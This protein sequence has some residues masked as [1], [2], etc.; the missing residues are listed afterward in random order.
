VL[1]GGLQL[2]E[3][4]QAGRIR[5]ALPVEGVDVNHPG[6]G[7]LASGT[8]SAG[9]KFSATDR[10]ADVA[11]LDA[12]Y[13]A[14]N[15]L[16]VGSAITVAGT[17]FHLIGLVNQSQL[18]GATDIYLPL[19]RAQALVHGQAD[20]SLTGQVNV[21]YVTAISSAQIPD[22]QGE[23]NR[24]LPAATVT[25]TND[26]AGQVAGSLGSTAN[27][28]NDLGKWVAAAALLAAF[29][30]ASLLT[31]AAVRRRTRELGTLRA[32]GW[33]AKRII[34]QIMS[35]S[36]ATGLIGA[37]LGIPIGVGGTAVVD[38]AAPKLPAILPQQNGSGGT[39]TVAVHLAAHLSP[40]TVL[41]AILL[42]IAGALIAGATGARRASQLPPAD[43]FAQ[44]D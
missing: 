13:A 36:A 23:I 27:L 40:A 43:A 5:Q 7:P 22:V 29:A 37:V 39:T 33:P 21:M 4:T 14:A 35:E 19:A 18:S 12:N 6:L 8:L 24:L 1:A 11:I 25:D 28:T 15:K 9:D 42:T 44:I 31:T 38:A 34:T 32:L 20:K 16:A 3:L 10:S 17:T 26:L 30:V 41:A 2:S